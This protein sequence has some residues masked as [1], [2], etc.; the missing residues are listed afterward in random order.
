MKLKSSLPTELK[1]QAVVIEA[2]ARDAGLDFFEVEFELLPASAVNGVAAYCGFPVRY[3]SWRFGMEYERLQKGYRWGLSKIYELVINNDPTIAY[4]VSANSLLEQKLV[5]AHVYGHADFFKHN[6]WFQPTDRKMLDTM[7]H[8]CGRVRR[9]VDAVGQERVERFMDSVLSIET[10]IDPY[11]P[12][13]ERQQ[14]GA[15][16]PSA[17]RPLSERA[18][19]SLDALTAPVL[20]SADEPAPQKSHWAPASFDILGFLA[21]HAPVEEW[22]RDILRML[23]AEA[24]YFAPQRM[25]KIMNEGWA[26]FWHSRL[27]TGGILEP[28]EILDFADCH[29]S[30]TATQPGQLNPYKLGIELFRYA[31]ESGRDIFQL[32]RVHNDVSMIDALLDEG[33]I[34]HCM[35]AD[36]RARPTEAGEEDWRAG[37]A[38]LLRDLSWGGLPKIELAEVDAA[39]EGEL[40]LVHHHDGRDLQLDQ[41]SETLRNVARLWRAPV[42]LWTMEEGQG[43]SLVCKEDEVVVTECGEAKLR[44]SGDDELPVQRAAG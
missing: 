4:L 16:M 42:H 36:E 21:E 13:R 35:S 33:F 1:Y 3:P 2:A 18:R 39:G 19:A 12:L 34:E 37:K 11:L 40:R 26:S 43:R 14:S 27:L 44:C 10:L 15:G 17:L 20:S 24:Y 22:E 5:M 23:R 7:G 29:S 41:A 9:Y 8:H 28:G 6:T 31:E 25:T 30:A 32:R 38:R